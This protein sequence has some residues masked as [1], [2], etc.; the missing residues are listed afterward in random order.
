M[1]TCLNPSKHQIICWLNIQFTISLELL[2]MMEQKLN[3]NGLNW[4]LLMILV[5]LLEFLKSLIKDNH[6][7]H[8]NLKIKRNIV[9]LNRSL[10]WLWITLG[11]IGGL[12]VVGGVGFVVYTK[13]YKRSTPHVTDSAKVSLMQ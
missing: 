6:L 4:E 1:L 10:T 9:F 13:F 11:V 2:F 3:H 5:K 8:L 12:I 7:L